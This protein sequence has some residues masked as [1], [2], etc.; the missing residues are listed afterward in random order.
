VKVSQG[1]IIGMV[2][3]KGAGKASINNSKK[4]S[5]TYPYR[6][7]TEEI[8]STPLFA[9]PVYALAYSRRLF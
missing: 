5:K 9:N 4:T 1:E 8:Y 7:Q 2:A 6:I 3:R